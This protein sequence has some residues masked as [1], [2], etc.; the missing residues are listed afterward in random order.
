[1]IP[2]DVLMAVVVVVVLVKSGLR[3]KTLHPKPETL[4]PPFK[5]A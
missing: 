2:V 3:P 1:M 5:E 4:N